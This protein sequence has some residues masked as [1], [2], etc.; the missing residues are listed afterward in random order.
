M[1]AETQ[2][3]KHEENEIQTENVRQAGDVSGHR[4]T[5]GPVL[6]PRIPTGRGPWALAVTARG[7]E[8]SGSPEAM[9]R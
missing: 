2:V 8:R 7:L 1:Y 5:G 3:A 9:D 4:P 6:T